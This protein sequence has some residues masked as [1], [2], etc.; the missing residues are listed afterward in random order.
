MTSLIE[1]M[2]QRPL[3]PLLQG[4]VVWPRAQPRLR[5]LTLRDRMSKKPHGHVRMFAGELLQTVVF[6]G[7]FCQQVLMPGKI[8][9]PDVECFVGVGRI[10]YLLRG[11]ALAVAKVDL[12]EK[13]I[14]EHHD[15]FMALY[16]KCAKIKVHLLLHVP[17][18]I[19]RFLHNLSCFATERKHKASKSICAFATVVQKKVL[20]QKCDLTPLKNFLMVY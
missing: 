17:W 8:L 20:V 6:L 12:L 10:L 11:G 15:K 18:Q 16:P 2:P 3:K 14:L 13:L 9:V 19:R 4:R 1:L 5:K 7:I